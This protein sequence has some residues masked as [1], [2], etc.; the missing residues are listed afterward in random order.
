MQSSTASTYLEPG[1]M[2][3]RDGSA[4][5]QR[6]MP[7]YVKSLAMEK[8]RADEPSP[9]VI[10]NGMTQLVTFVS[11]CLLIFASLLYGLAL[12]VGDGISRAGHSDSTTISEIVISND[13]LNIPSNAIRYSAQ[14]Y[15]GTQSRL[16]VYLHWPSLSGYT[17]ALRE[18]FNNSG[19]TTNLVFLTIE[20][21]TMSHD[22]S[23]RIQP[24]YARFFDGPHESGGFGLIR[25][26]LSAEGG[27]IDE[28]LYYEA[29]SP[30]P[31]AARCVRPDSKIS[32]PF[33]IRDIHVGQEL[34]LTYRFHTKFLGNW[35]ALERGIRQWMEMVLVTNAS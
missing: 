35:M 33:C 23:G 31:F 10:S 27:Y 12:L 1:Q 22:M 29:V 6:R 8:Q 26:P 13:V 20:P 14:R 16:E 5:F 2:V 21:R 15:S 25:Q 32:T 4:A 7:G 17:E 9:P 28:D 34:M 30:Y 11:A 3:G 19:E 18:E 24:I